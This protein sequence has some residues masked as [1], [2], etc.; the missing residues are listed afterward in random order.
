MTAPRTAELTLTE[1][2]YHQVRRM[3]ASQGCTV[4]TLH[5]SRFGELQLGV[6][7]E[8]RRHR[9]IAV[10]DRE[11][12]RERTDARDVVPWVVALGCAVAVSAALAAWRGPTRGAA[13]PEPT[14]A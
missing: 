5:R 8:P 4:L 2:K 7:A 10:V 14:R 12:L 1:G 3:F 13:P 9:V 11:P 6:R